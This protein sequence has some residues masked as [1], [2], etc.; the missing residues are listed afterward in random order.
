MKR[1]CVICR[2]K[3]EDQFVNRFETLPEQTIGDVKRIIHVCES[4][5][6]E[7]SLFSDKQNMVYIEHDLHNFY[8]SSEMV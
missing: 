1:V 8:P 3:T 7:K 5:K 2:T 4:C 6:E